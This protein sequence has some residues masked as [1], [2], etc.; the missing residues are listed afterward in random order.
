M[1]YHDQQTRNGKD[2]NVLTLVK[3]SAFVEKKQLKEGFES[4]DPKKVIN[5]KLHWLAVNKM[6]NDSNC[7]VDNGH[8]TIKL[9][10]RS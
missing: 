8:R 10:E 7:V 3:T 2:E 1:R 5:M 9:V 4:S 6:I